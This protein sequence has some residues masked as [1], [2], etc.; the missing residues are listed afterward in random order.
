MG[1]GQGCRKTSHRASRHS[2]WPLLPPRQRAIQPKMSATLK[3]INPALHL[4]LRELTPYSGQGEMGCLARD[5]GLGQVTSVPG[6]MMKARLEPT[7]SWHGSS[8]FLLPG[9]QS[10]LDPHSLPRLHNFSHCP[11][12]LWPVSS[13]IQWSTTGEAVDELEGCRADDDSAAPSIAA[14]VGR[15]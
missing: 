15:V 14:G 1:W 2:P 5:K 13:S 10:A 7:V 9:E 8:L 4:T 11:N 6:F 3:G 12:P